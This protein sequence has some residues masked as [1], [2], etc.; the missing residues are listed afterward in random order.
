MVELSGHVDVETGEEQSEDNL[1]DCIPLHSTVRLQPKELEAHM[2]RMLFLLWP[3]RGTGTGSI[4][5]EATDWNATTPWLPPL[6][7][8]EQN[9]ILQK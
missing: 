3:S 9:H 4:S 6:G 5:H 1:T 7:T 2:L 8:L